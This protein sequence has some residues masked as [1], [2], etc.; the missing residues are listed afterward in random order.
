MLNRLLQLQTTLAFGN[1][2][3]VKWSA[4]VFHCKTIIAIVCLF[5]FLAFR[6][7]GERAN[8]KFCTSKSLINTESKFNLLKLGVDGTMSSPGH[9]FSSLLIL[10]F[11]SAHY[12][13]ASIV[14]IVFFRLCK[15]GDYLL[16]HATHMH[17][18][19]HEKEKKGI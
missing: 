2:I 7:S 4:E 1:H 14:H 19:T 10:H 16:F 5:V 9:F 11:K 15:I 18:H 13:Y 3:S 8:E 12:D 6:V 17:V